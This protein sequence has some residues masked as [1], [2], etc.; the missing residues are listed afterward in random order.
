M[1]RV[2]DWLVD[3]LDEPFDLDKLAALTH[4]SPFHFHRVYTAMMGERV[5]ETVR[6]MRLQRAGVLLYSSNLPI[7]TIARKSGYGSVQAFT[8]V[9]SQAYGIGPAQYRKHATQALAMANARNNPANLL[10]MPMN[11]AFTDTDLEKAFVHMKAEIVTLAAVPAIAYRHHGSYQTIGNSFQKLTAW[12]AGRHLLGPTTKMY[13]IYYDMPDSKPERE[14]L[15]DACI[16]VPVSFNLEGAP[17]GLS[18][19]HTPDGLAAQTVFKGPYADLPMA[20][21]W[22]FKTWLPDNGYEPGDQPALEEYL[23]D[24]RTTAPT[25]LLTAVSIPVKG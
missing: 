8:R 23:N 1:Q 14:L 18:L 21:A 2:T 11:R 12:A 13:G 19:T 16:S 9:F 5:A 6:R 10:E 3:H 25:E 4:F 20:Y 22:L 24:P 7:M 17:P 15:S